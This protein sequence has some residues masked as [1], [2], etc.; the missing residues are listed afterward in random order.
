M[1]WLIYRNC[2]KFQASKFS[3]VAA[4]SGF[5]EVIMFR[6]CAYFFSVVSPYDTIHGLSELLTVPRNL[7]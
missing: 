6:F 5:I 2:R 4:Y 3:R 7:F 1:T